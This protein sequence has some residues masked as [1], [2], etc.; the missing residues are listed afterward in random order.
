MGA[1]I[2]TGGYQILSMVVENLQFLDLFNYL[3]I[4]LK[5][6]PISFDLTWEKRYYPH[7]FNTTNNLDYVGPHPEHK[8]YGADFMWGDERAIFSA[9]YVG[10]RTTFLTIRRNSWRIAWTTSMYWG[11][12][13]VLF[14]IYFWNWS[15]WILFGKLLLYHP[16]AI[17]CSE[18]CF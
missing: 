1:E 15:K 4:S 10:S 12:H 7:F 2:D 17:R 11:R 18:L 8:L 6:M 14:G 9:W 16:F 13:A 3:P 5:S